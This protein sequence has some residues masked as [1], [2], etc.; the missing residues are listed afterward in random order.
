MERTNADDFRSNLKEWME[1]ARSEP[2]KITR[3]TGEAFVLI[4]AD[5]FEKIQ[6]ELA[7]LRGVAQGL[8][9]IV[10]GRV[11]KSQLK[12]TDSAIER[13][14]ERVLGKKNKKAVG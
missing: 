6:I 14:K 12:S 13:A 1:S 9:D 7:S 3:K 10:N 4:N 8:S 2:V 5:E 11:K